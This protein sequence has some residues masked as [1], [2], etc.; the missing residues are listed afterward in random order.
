MY[1][2][3]RSHLA[4]H[5]VRLVEWGF[6]ALSASKAIFR[7]RTYNCNLFSPVMMMNETRRK[8]TTGR[9]SP[10]LFDKWHGIFYMPSRIDEAGH[11]K[12]FDYPVAEHWGESQRTKR[13][14]VGF[15]PTSAHTYESEIQRSTTSGGF[16]LAH[17]RRANCLSTPGVDLP[18]VNL[19]EPRTHCPAH[20]ASSAVPSERAPVEAPTAYYPTEHKLQSI[21]QAFQR[22]QQQ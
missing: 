8:P 5:T 7:A 9:H 21:H 11:T 14:L 4:C 12:A 19:C 18:A 17:Q 13:S 10:S 15:E 2:L 1:R 6:Y 3:R 20:V 16:S 22:R